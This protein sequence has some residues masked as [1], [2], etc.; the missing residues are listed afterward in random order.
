MIRR[1]SE[2]KLYVDDL[3]S[4]LQLTFRATAL[5]DWFDKEFIA[6]EGNYRFCSQ[7]FSDGKE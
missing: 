5:K 3:F 4:S 7:C 6:P 1:D 2:I